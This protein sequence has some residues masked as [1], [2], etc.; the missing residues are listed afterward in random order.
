MSEVGELTS[1]NVKIF[2][3]GVKKAEYSLCG[4]KPI[5]QNPL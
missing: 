4:A 2:V 5:G 3:A 1:C